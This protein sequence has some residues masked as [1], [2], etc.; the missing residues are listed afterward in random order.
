MQ[1]PSCT[2]SHGA[3]AE[4]TPSPAMKRQ[5]LLAVFLPGES[6]WGLST[7]NSH[8]WLCRHIQFQTPRKKAGVLH[9]PSARARSLATVSCPCQLTV[10]W[11]LS[12][13]QIPRLHSPPRGQ[14]AFPGTAV[15]ALSWELCSEHILALLLQK[16]TFSLSWRRFLMVI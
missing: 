1:A 15:V 8:C 13:F 3:H 2:P 10:P 16:A 12:W 7:Q 9:N 6:Y 4:P 5:Q 11:T 14:Q